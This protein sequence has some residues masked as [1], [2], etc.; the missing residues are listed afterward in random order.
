V[1]GISTESPQEMSDFDNFLG[2]PEVHSAFDHARVLVLPMPF[3]ATVSYGGGTQNGPAA[4]ITASQQVE[5]YEFAGA[6]AFNLR[7]T[8]H[9]VDSCNS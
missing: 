4:I 2:L 1:T 7:T 5:L 9:S 3:E 6:G 8:Y